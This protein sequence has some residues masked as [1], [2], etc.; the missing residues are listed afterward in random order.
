MNATAETC[1][2]NPVLRHLVEALLCI[3]TD[4]DG[5]S[6]DENYSIC[7]FD[8]DCLDKLYAKFQQ[9]IDKCE[10]AI[11]AKLGGDWESLEDFYLGSYVDG[12]V[13]R[14]F[15]FTASR[16]GS[17]FWDKGRWDTRV[18]DLLTKFAHEFSEIEFNPPYV[19]DDGKLYF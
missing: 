19:G 1:I 18:S 6:L 13:E 5:E 9:F 17:G 10:A 12:C 11:T 3:S 4:H 15:I 2:N 14:D 16:S 8:K 7:D